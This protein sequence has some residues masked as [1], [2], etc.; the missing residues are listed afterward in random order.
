MSQHHS[1][2]AGVVLSYPGRKTNRTAADALADVVSLAILLALACFGVAVSFRHTMAF[3]AA[4]GQHTG[5]IIVGT[6]CTVVLVTLQSAIEIW[7]DSRAGRGRGAPVLIFSVGVVVE[8]AANASTATG[9]GLNAVVAAWPV[10]VAATAVWLWT[11][12][13]QHAAEAAE[14]AA[15]AEI[16]QA[17]AEAAGPAPLDPEP[18]AAPLDLDQVEPTTI[19]ER[20]F[21][22]LA[23]AERPLTAPELADAV[24]AD[25]RYAWRLLQEWEAAHD[26]QVPGQLDG[27]AAIAE[28]AAA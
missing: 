2:T 4:H 13:L 5:W 19:K 20:A 27:L 14:R 8:L 3:I 18:H 6:A 25:R 21:A 10:P 9:G 17:P 16:D 23:A 7:R 22:A 11:R 24:G 15:L 12:R 28:G 1:T 26:N